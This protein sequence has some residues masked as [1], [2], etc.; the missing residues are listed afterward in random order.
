MLLPAKLAIGGGAL[1]LFSGIMGSRAARRAARSLSTDPNDFD[2]G[3]GYVDQL[4]AQQ[5]G[6][7]LTREASSI[8]RAGGGAYDQGATEQSLARRGLG[9]N[10]FSIL[11]Q[12]AR[13]EGQQR[14]AT[15][16]ADVRGGLERDQQGAVE[17]LLA[18]RMQAKQFSIGTANA[19]RLA[20]IGIRSQAAQNVWG[21]LG[22]IGGMSLGMG[23]NGALAPAS[24]GPTGVTGVPQPAGTNQYSGGYNPQT[25]TYMQSYRDP[26]NPTGP[27]QTSLTTVD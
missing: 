12:E 16:A 24:P 5:R 19:N 3:S 20:K 26:W 25:R 7:N 6:R 23:L 11:E 13:E 8:V 22:N 4:I 21:T 14:A 17:R 2:P 15:M 9:A 27:L 10:A 1:S 18:Q